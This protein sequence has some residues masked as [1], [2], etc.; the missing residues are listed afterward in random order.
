[1]DDRSTMI[2][3]AKI[4]ERERNKRELSL[5]ELANYI[6]FDDKGKHLMSASYLNR[7]ENNKADSPGF[8]NVCLLI[9][10]LSLDVREVFKSFGY[11]KL[12]KDDKK[13]ESI[14]EI[15]RYSSIKAPLYQDSGYVVK[16]GYLDFNEKEI[17]L[18]IIN[19]IFSIGVCTE[20]SVLLNLTEIIKEIEEY[21]RH[22]K[23]K[24]KD[25][26]N[27]LFSDDIPYVNF[28]V[29]ITSVAKSQIERL[30]ITKEVFYETIS[31]YHEKINKLKDG[32]F[33]LLIKEELLSVNITIDK[34]YLIINSISKY[35]E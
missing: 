29:K 16:D 20:E 11:Q 13:W 6:G 2:S 5:V 19:A 30:G 35:I 31:S 34:I 14:E 7:L 10:R 9:D 17:L 27:R 32:D 24:G 15:I 26:I 28:S 21:R 18:S 1:M 22:R 12:F 33:S 25:F 8:R 3:F 23:L 4:I